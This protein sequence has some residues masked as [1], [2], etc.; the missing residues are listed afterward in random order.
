MEDLLRH[1]IVI[2]HSFRLDVSVCPES[3]YKSL[4]VH[5]TT[6]TDF[7]ILL[8]SKEISVSE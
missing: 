5:G 8:N 4:K 2:P 3:T 6:T 7:I 1:N